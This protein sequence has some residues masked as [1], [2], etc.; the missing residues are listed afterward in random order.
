VNVDEEIGNLKGTWTSEEESTSSENSNNYGNNEV[1]TQENVAAKRT[2]VNIYEEDNNS[3]WLQAT[4]IVKDWESAH[5]RYL[6]G[7][8][9]DIALKAA[10]IQLTQKRGI[11]RLD[12]QKWYNYDSNYARRKIYLLQKELGLLVPLKGRHRIGRFQQY[13]ISTELDKF[14]EDQNIDRG[15]DD[16]IVEREGQGRRTLIQH[17]VSTLSKRKPTFHKLYLYAKL[18]PELYDDLN[19]AVPSSRNKAKVKEFPIEHRRSVRFEIYPE[20]TAG[21]YMVSTANA[22]ELHTP[23]GLID[24]F[25]SLGEARSILKAECKDLRRIPPVNSWKLKMFDKDKTILVSEL[26]KDI[27]QVMRLWSDEGIRVEHLGEVFQIYG[28]VMPETGSAFRFEAQSTVDD[29]EEEQLTETLIKETFPEIKFK[30]AFDMINDL[31]KR[32]ERLESNKGSS[33]L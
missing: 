33:I 4:K 20:G 29:P 28:K 26:E 23:K 1:K 16:S 15:I 31:K 12:L 27:P 5:H 10:Y 9:K 25:S 32:V 18:P 24:F 14:N 30:T 19:W 6:R 17:L 7:K 8:N 22:Y 11:V 21:I 13:C 3:R 2:E